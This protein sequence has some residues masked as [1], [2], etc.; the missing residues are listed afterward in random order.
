VRY[1]FLSVAVLIAVAGGS[2]AII[3]G[4]PKVPDAAG[5]LKAAS[6]V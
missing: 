4:R 5:A 1:R 2:L 6:L 3:S